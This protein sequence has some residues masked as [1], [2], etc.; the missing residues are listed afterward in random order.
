MLVDRAEILLSVKSTRI[1]NMIS[2]CGTSQSHMSMELISVALY[3]MP[4]KWY[5]STKLRRNKQIM[6]ASQHSIQI[7]IFVPAIFHFAPSHRSSSPVFFFYT[8]AL[9]VCTLR[10]LLNEKK[11]TVAIT[12]VTSQNSMFTRSIHTAFFILL[13]SPLP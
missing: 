11:A 3:K 8:V 13:V 2:F 7:W 12:A 1:S 10:L 6:D 5:H 4:A 9:P